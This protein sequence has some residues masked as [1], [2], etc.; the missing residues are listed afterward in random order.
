MFPPRTWFLMFVASVS[1]PA[2]IVAADDARAPPGRLS[3]PA[4]PAGQAAPV[5]PVQNPVAGPAVQGL[6]PQATRP[7]LSMM[8]ITVAPSLCK[9]I[10][11]GVN[12]FFQKVSAAEQALTQ[13]QGNP[14]HISYHRSN[15]QSLFLFTVNKNCCAKNVSY[16]AQ[17]QQAAGCSGGDSVAVCMDKLTRHC[18]SNAVKMSKIREDLQKTGSAAANLGEKSDELAQEIQDLLKILP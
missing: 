5:V 17:D 7:A 15:M 18:I 16:S 2:A 13:A 6:A 14:S 11:D 9:S 12:A 1:W 4:A 8:A 3:M 10:P